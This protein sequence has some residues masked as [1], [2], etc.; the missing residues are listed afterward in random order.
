MAKSKGNQVVG[1]SGFDGG[2]LAKHSDVSLQIS[3][4]KG[5]YGPVEDAHSIIGHITGTYLARHF[6]ND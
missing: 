2:Y 5:E 6:S 4:N 3:S 1:I